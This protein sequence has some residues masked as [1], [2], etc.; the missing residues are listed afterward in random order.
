MEWGNYILIDWSENGRNPDKKWFS[1]FSLHF[2]I[3]IKK[4]V[5]IFI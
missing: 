2:F 1:T 4:Y 5:I 3:F